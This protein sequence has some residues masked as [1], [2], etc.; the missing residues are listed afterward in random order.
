MATGKRPDGE[1]FASGANEGEVLDFPAISRGW[2]VTTDGKDGSGNKVTDPTNGIPP[3]EWFNALQ[4]RTDEAIQWLLQNALPDWAAG[5]WPAGAVV[6]NGGVVWRAQKETATEPA[7]DAGDWLALFPVANLDKRYLNA[8]KNLSDLTDT[9]KARKALSLDKVGNWNAVQANGGLHSS[10]NHHIYIDWGG[11]SKFHGTVDSTDVGEFFTTQNPPTAAQAGAVPMS[12]GALNEE[13]SLSVISSVKDGASGQSLYGPLFRSCMKGRGGD[14]DFK[15]GGSVAFRIVE[16]VSNYAFAEILFDGYSS[17]QSF[18]F[19]NDGTI[20]S[21]GSVY[22]GGAYI[23]TDGNIYGSVW[24]GFLNNWIA[25]QISAQ[26]G[27]AQ[28]WVSNTFQPRNTADLGGGWEKDSVTG[29]IR[30][31]GS[32][33]AG[34]RGHYQVN[35]PITFPN[36]CANVQV[37]AV[38]NGV[39]VY[40]DNYATAGNVTQAG[41]LCGQDNNGAYWEAIGW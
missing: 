19:R 16:V 31:W 27:A 4:K 13:A 9:A 32:I 35:F 8:D 7:A 26:V 15:D 14:G 29:R 40:S 18:Q 5:T 38:D 28:T 41:F 12:G 39:T 36:A 23:A 1:V 10:G 33:N 17:I 3:M 11:D 34:T 25:G 6:V 2:G 21:P 24:G 37:T 20:R 30:Q 22:A